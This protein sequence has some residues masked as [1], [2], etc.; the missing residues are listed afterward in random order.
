M[1]HKGMLSEDPENHQSLP[2]RSHISQVLVKGLGP[3]Y[4][5]TRL[6][7]NGSNKLSYIE[8]WKII[9]LANEIFGFDG[10]NSTVVKTEIDYVCPSSILQVSLAK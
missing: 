4:I 5:S 3:E 2:S 9:N 10:W 1:S 7:P 6:G 8:G